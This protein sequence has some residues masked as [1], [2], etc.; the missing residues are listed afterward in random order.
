MGFS[1]LVC[2]APQ[3]LLFSADKV[4][5]GFRP[6]KGVWLPLAASQ[7]LCLPHPRVSKIVSYLDDWESVSFDDKRKVVDI[8]ISKIDATS[9]N[10]TIH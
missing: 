8:L 2:N 3:H 7:T 4:G 5:A 9:E 6:Q 1:A 10:I